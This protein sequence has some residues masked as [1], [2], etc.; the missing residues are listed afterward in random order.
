MPGVRGIAVSTIRGKRALV[1]L[2]AAVAMMAAG[3]GGSSQPS[4]NKVASGQLPGAEVPTGG[5]SANAKSSGSTVPLAQ[6]NPIT[7][8]FSAIGTF[9]SCL[10]GLGVTF[11]GAPNPSD[12]SSGAN[13][14]AY[15]KA[16]TTCA[17]QSNIV[18]AL[19][20]EQ[21][22]QQN[23]TQSQ[24]KKENQEYLLWR[25][26]MISLGWGIPQPTPN[27][28]GLLFSFGGTGAQASQFKPPPGQTLLSSPDLQGCAN[29]ALSGHS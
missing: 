3:C 7:T 22:A 6:A 18:Q 20:A 29:K 23:L 1:A 15:V 21:T 12:P 24:I 11:I 28:Q 16:L 27:S 9:Q 2:V 10:T 4:A 19:K 14:P 8:L 26:C 13:D 25:T 5:S 17:S